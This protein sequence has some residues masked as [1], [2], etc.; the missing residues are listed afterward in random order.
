M[1]GLAERGARL[2]LRTA[3]GSAGALRGSPTLARPRVDA[4]DV[5]VPG[6][7]RVEVVVAGLSFP[8]AIEFAPDGTVFIAEGGSTWPTWP[9]MPTRLLRLDPEGR[10]R[11]S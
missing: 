7:Y 1:L 4:Q 6:G 2:R 10:A 8:T 11:P 3:E 5:G 9:Y